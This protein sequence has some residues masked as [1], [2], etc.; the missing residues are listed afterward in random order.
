[1]R[2]KNLPRYHSFCVNDTTQATTHSY[3][4]VRLNAATRGR[5]HSQGAFAPRDFTVPAPKGYAVSSAA[6]SHQIRALCEFSALCFFI[7][8]FEV[9]V[10]YFLLI[11]KRF[12]R[13]S[14]RNLNF[15]QLFLQTRILLRAALYRLFMPLLATRQEVA[16]KRAKTFP[17]GSPFH[18][19]ATWRIKRDYIKKF[20]A[21]PQ[22]LP[23]R[24]AGGERKI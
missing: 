9:I 19:R 10:A 18:C 11:V 8:A 20:H 2:R 6:R 15:K 12:G 3:C 14:R 23:S 24:A 16:K 1:M 7:I 21:V 22:I 13:E 5:L 4:A 17:L